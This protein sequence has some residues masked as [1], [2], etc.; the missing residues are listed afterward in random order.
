MEHHRAGFKLPALG[1]YFCP[2][3]I[4]DKRQP[5]PFI[6]FLTGK[7]TSQLAWEDPHVQRGWMMCGLGERAHS[8]Q[9]GQVLLLRVYK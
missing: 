5:E 7:L 2:S 6:F 9:I 4:R 3:G 1:N 8:A